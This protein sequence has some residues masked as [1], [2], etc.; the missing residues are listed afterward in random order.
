MPPY[1]GSSNVFRRV[2]RELDPALV[3]QYPVT[4]VAAKVL[5]DRDTVVPITFP[6]KSTDR[7]GCPTD[8]LLGTQYPEKQSYQLLKS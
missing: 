3:A 6:A 4:V 1:N 8:V 5:H 2:V 7:K